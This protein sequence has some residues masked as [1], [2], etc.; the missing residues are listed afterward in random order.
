[1]QELGH[2]QPTENPYA[3]PDDRA[4]RRNA[5]QLFAHAQFQRRHV[6]QCPRK[7]K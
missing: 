6:N 5:S 3:P 7:H 2:F 1:M 4:A